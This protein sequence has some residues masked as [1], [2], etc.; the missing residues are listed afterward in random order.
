MG[1]IYGDVSVGLGEKSMRTEMKRGTN[2]KEYRIVKLSD[3]RAGKSIRCGGHIGRAEVYHELTN[4]GKIACALAGLLEEL[5]VFTVLGIHIGDAPISVVAFLWFLF[6]V[7]S[8]AM[9]IGVD[10]LHESVKRRLRVLAQIRRRQKLVRA[11]KLS[12]A[13]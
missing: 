9:L 11:Q 1:R 7:L 4:D 12:A 5:V 6:G 2:A 8:A 13:A 10:A 3:Q